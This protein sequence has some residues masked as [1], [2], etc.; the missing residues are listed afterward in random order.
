MKH[1]KFCCKAVTRV[2][3]IYGP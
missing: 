2:K 1:C 3:L